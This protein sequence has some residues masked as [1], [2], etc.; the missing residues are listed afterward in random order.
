MPLIPNLGLSDGKVEKAVL[1][2]V[3]SGSLSKL[4]KPNGIMPI[5]YFPPFCEF[6]P[7]GLSD[8]NKVEK[9]GL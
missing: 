9:R 3:R 2:A 4:L 8:G 1:Y 7:S 5:A 6:W